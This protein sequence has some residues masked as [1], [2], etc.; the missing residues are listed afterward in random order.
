MPSPR[1]GVFGLAL[2]FLAFQTVLTGRPQA[3]GGGKEDVA[4]QIRFGAEMAKQGNWHEAIFRWQRALAVEPGNSRLHNNLAV[5]YESLGDY[6]KADAEYAAA[7]ASAVVADEVR[8]N[9]ELF[10][11]F[12]GPHKEREAGPGSGSPAPQAPPEPG[13]KP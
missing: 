9:H 3:A 4:R 7:L 11:R 5:A 12:Y 10:L 6:A 1:V 2:F 8:H 13:G